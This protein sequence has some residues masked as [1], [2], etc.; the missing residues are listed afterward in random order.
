M[1]YRPFG[2]TG[3]KVSSLVLG[4]DNLANPTPESE[5]LA[6]LDAAVAGGINLI[7]TSNSYAAG[8]TTCWWPPRSSTPPAR[9]STI[10]A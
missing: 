5:S 6:I 10:G 9:A 1:Q 8:A 4:T 7:D 2:R 3:L